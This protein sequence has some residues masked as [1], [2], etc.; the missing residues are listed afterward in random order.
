MT[1]GL[2]ALGSGEV[3]ERAGE[4]LAA[5]GVAIALP[6]DDP[7]HPDWLARE[8][9]LVPEVSL[10]HGLWAEG[11]L[12]HLLRFGLTPQA[13]PPALSEL[14]EATL[15]LCQAEQAA[16]VIV[17]ETVGLVGAALQTPPAHIAGDGFAFPDIRDRM[18]FTAEPAHTDET[19]V[20]VGFV[21]REPIPPL[22]DFLRPLGG[23]STLY[24]HCHAAVT[25]YRPVQK[26]LL[27][28]SAAM[29][30]LLDS[31]TVRGVLHLLND[32]R[33]GVGAGESYLRRGALWCGP[34]NFGEV[35]P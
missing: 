17:A 27:D 35:L 26:G 28:L 16:L 11:S 31:Q 15:T 13:P 8:G 25:P 19:C 18:L 7:A 23:G 6:G 9:E 29:A 12:H 4:L 3:R 32:D 30:A 34:V 21:A 33:E 20:I 22:A 24:A 10:L 1:V 2:G 14:A 5:S